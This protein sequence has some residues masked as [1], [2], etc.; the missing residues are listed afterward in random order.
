M[1]ALLFFL[2]INLANLFSFLLFFPI[3]DVIVV[4]CLKI[5][6]FKIIFLRVIFLK[7]FNLEVLF[8]GVLVFIFALLIVDLFV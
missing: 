1:L 4:M 8:F 5:N 2:L 6:C 3:Y 7:K